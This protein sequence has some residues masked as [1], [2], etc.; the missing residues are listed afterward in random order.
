[1]A[2]T[3][4]ALA[5]AI[6]M[7]A[8][9]TAAELAVFMLNEA[10]VRALAEEGTRGAA[11]LAQ[12]RQR[13]ERTLVL[14]R[15]L[16][17][18]ADVSA[19]ALAA[20]LV[21]QQWHLLGLAAVIGLVTLL[22]LYLGELLPLGIAANHGVRLAL[23]IAPT[24]LFMTRVLSPLLV[25]LA[26]L[27]NLHPDRRE[28]PTATITE[29]EIRQ[30]TALGHNEGGIEEHE[31]ELI[32]RAFRLDETKTW[33]I[34]TPRVDVFAWRDSL[35]L[36]QIA[37][38]LGTVR[39]SRVPVYGE[40]IDDITGVLYVRDAYQA[41]VGGQ[42]DVS[43]RALAR[44]PLIVPGS[45]TLTKLLRDFQTRR[46][47][48]AVVVD[49]YGG[50]DGLVTLEDVI[51]ELVGEIVDETDVAEDLIVR[52]SRSD[53]VA[54]GDADLREI[55]HIFNTAFPQ[56]EHRS[57]NGY[58]LEELGRVPE[59]GESLEREGVRIE[60]LE[61]TD[62]QVLRARLRRRNPA[63]E[64]V[65]RPQLPASAEAEDGGTR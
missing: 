12:L 55:N 27:A 43:L 22:V 38:E 56:L 25:V 8:L 23:A 17:T 36:A 18:L 32:E 41:L 50:T 19:G 10:R 51:E 35:T 62:T 28:G 42:R 45:V 37:S 14:L 21:F 59:T 60:V 1:M 5:I 48:L 15:F 53:I 49:E 33:G 54:A 2:V 44:E 58:L 30:L 6:L 61:A 4:A 20:Y 47:H 65:E 46:I 3:I 52:I 11:A 7:S 57:L 31:R 9:L 16:D 40:S 39:Y 13:P 34:M 63:G 29:T 26:R 64:G 24:L